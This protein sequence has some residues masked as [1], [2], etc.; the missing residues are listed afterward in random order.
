MTSWN[1]LPLWQL[2]SRA[3]T[4]P[5]SSIHLLS[6]ECSV[7]VFC[8]DCFSQL[9]CSLCL[10]I[11]VYR[12]IYIYIY[13]CICVYIVYIYIRVCTWVW[14]VRICIY[15]PRYHLK[16]PGPLI[17]IID[18]WKTTFF[19]LLP[20]QN[21]CRLFFTKGSGNNKNRNWEH[22]VDS[23]NVEWSVY[24]LICTAH[25]ISRFFCHLP[26]VVCP[27]TSSTLVLLC[28]L[29]WAFPRPVL[30]FCIL[31]VMIPCRAFSREVRVNRGWV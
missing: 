5:T 19:D 13:M 4:W 11:C 24:N 12:Y 30:Y 22:E 14:R 17:R 7:C 20:L 25:S 23:V 27:K 8:N 16:C 18:P 26:C 9:S 10:D 2:D 29:L 21:G 15:T 1:L 31:L 3:T 6:L 28:A